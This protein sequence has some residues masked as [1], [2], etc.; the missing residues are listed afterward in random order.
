MKFG[1]VVGKILVYGYEENEL[2]RFPCILQSM[3]TQIICTYTIFATTVALTLQTSWCSHWES[4]RPRFP[5]GTTSLQAG[6]TF[7]SL[8]VSDVLYTHHSDVVQPCPYIHKDT[9]RC[10]DL[11]ALKYFK[12]IDS[13]PLNHR[14]LLVFS[15]TKT[16]ILHLFAS[17]LSRFTLEEVF[18]DDFMVFFYSDLCQVPAGCPLLFETSSA[19]ATLGPKA[20]MEMTKQLEMHQR[21]SEASGEGGWVVGHQDVYIHLFT[22]HLEASEYGFTKSNNTGKQKSLQ[23]VDTKINC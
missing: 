7:H 17:L 13:A 6:S 1:D 19:S 11:I 5:A 9:H 10:T 15:S 16:L 12:V 4:V 8:H 23:I 3:H 2:K 21:K 18:P 14:I 20:C 22:V